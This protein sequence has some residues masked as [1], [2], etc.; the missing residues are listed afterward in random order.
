[1]LTH[2]AAAERN[3]RLPAVRWTPQGL[4]EVDHGVI[5]RLALPL[6]LYASLQAILNLTDTWFLGRLSSVAVAG[7]G[8][9][10]WLVLG[11][12]FLLTGISMA[13]QAETAQAQGAGR[14]AD[15]AVATWSAL[16]LSLASLPVFA[17]IAGL[18][19]LLIGLLGIQPEMA[20]QAQAY[21]GPRLLGGPAAVA[22]V[23]LLS[24]CLGSGRS[25]TALLINLV[26]ALANVLLNALA[27][28]G[29][30]L[31]VSG[32][33]WATTGSLLVGVAAGLLVFLGRRVHQE[34]SSRG[35]WRPQRE[36]LWRLLVLGVPLGA[37]IAFDILGIAAFQ[38]MISLLGPAEA[39]VTQIL[40]MLTSLA[41]LPAV[42]FGKAATTLV[43]R[44][45]GAGDPD[46]ARRV[47]SRVIALSLAYMA[48]AGL[49][50]GLAGP[51]IIGQFVEPQDPLRPEILA[52]G[53]SLVWIAAVY[54]PLDAIHLGSMF[55]LRGVGDTSTPA[56]LVLIMSWGVFIPLTHLLVFERGEGWLP[57]LPGLGLGVMGGWVSMAVYI[58]VL[59]L[60]LGVRWQAQWW[61]RSGRAVD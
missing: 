32:V 50:I 28:Y 40:M 21:W 22:L 25:A 27:V 60:V 46:W 8:A 31:G 38:A 3:T 33:A 58:A 45:I 7:V 23:A 5:L 35:A 37:A 15:S 43:G 18:G 29:L 48:C 49:A 36:G 42:G 39:A 4:R 59:A 34:V 61:R 11:I 55:C 57:F 10:H 19:P 24:F 17:A 53:L 54:Q 6:V 30:D 14:E 20:D 26:V 41:Y 44:A 9:I 52:L 1:M 12:L 51:W 2:E 13:V 16:W 56:L 47:G